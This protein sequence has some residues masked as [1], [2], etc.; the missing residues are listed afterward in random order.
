METISSVKQQVIDLYPEIQSWRRHFHSHPELGF[1][2]INTASAIAAELRNAGLDVTE[3]VG[4]TGV[5][6]ILQ[7]KQPGRTVLLRFDI[8]ALPIHEEN[9]VD[10]KSIQLAVMHACGHDGHISV[11]L[12]CAKILASRREELKGTIKFVFQP[13]EEGL[14]GASAMIADGVLTHP[15]PDYVLAMHVWN[16]K[17]LGWMVL[18]PGALMAASDLV[19][20]TV[21][22][23][24]GHGAI[25]N[26]AIDPVLAAATVLIGLQSVISR[27]VSPLDE[28][29]MSITQFHTGDASNII[30]ASAFLRGSLRTTSAETRLIVMDRIESIAKNIA[31]GMGCTA[32]VSFSPVTP[33]VINDRELTLRIIDICREELPELQ[34]DT[35][36]H[37][38]VSDDMAMFMQE[39]PGCYMMVGS[40]NADAGLNY[41]HHHPRF[42]FDEHALVSGAALM[43]GTTLKLLS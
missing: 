8:D 15:R 38:M 24:G 41:S 1:Q 31:V 19:E 30:P 29:A 43:I 27:N 3:K 37:T 16:E 13:A 10:Y 9:E 23:K 4:K 34:I 20:V 39:I 26:K 32:E 6:G 35:E 17:P 25:P 7:G 11:G 5:V 12:A 33:P 14:G 42:D 18:H 22:G 2:E 21:L 40:A 28:V 36:Y